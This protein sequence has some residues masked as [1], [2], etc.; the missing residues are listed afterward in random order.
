[1]ESESFRD[2]DWKDW[3]GDV[4]NFHLLL[5]CRVMVDLDEMYLGDHEMVWDVR[6]LKVMTKLSRY[7]LKKVASLAYLSRWMN[8]GFRGGATYRVAISVNI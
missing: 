5:N 2:E 7:F 6:A 4:R 8:V 3:Y 1:M